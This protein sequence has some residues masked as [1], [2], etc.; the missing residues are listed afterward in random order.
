MLKIGDMVIDNK[1][2]KGIIHEIFIYK[3]KSYYN[4]INENGIYCPVGVG[5]YSILKIGELNEF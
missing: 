1:N 2:H 4:M 5:Y 3:K